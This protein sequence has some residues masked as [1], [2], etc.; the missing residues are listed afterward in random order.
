[1]ASTAR[2]TNCASQPA[3]LID[4]G[5]TSVPIPIVTHARI[6]IIHVVV[7]LSP[8]GLTRDLITQAVATAITHAMNPPYG[9]GLL[10][11]PVNAYSE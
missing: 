5:S 9:P 2:A 1:M 3:R 10:K 11:C 7:I 4:A 8:L 6:Y